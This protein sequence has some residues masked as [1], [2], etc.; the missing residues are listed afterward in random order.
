MRSLLRQVEERGR[1]AM[2]ATL[3]TLEEL[4]FPLS[5]ALAALSQRVRPKATYGAE[6]LLLRADWA[7][8]LDALQEHWLR[9]I[10]D[11]PR[12]GTR[13]QLMWEVGEGWRLSAW[14][15]GGAARLLAR[16]AALPPAHL[17]VRVRKIAAEEPTTW[18]ATVE[19]ELAALAIPTFEV[20]RAASSGAASTKAA[21]RK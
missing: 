19:R 11:I 4:G 8:R 16:I 15:L 14:V 21:V 12:G 3:T 6:F 9:R 20:W 13:Q 18:A 1:Y 5:A 17:A 2:R 7:C 10:L